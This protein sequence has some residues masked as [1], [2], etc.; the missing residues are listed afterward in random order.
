VD[1]VREV[2]S[3]EWFLDLIWGDE[4]CFVD[5]PSKAGGYW[6]P[7][8]GAWPEDRELILNRIDECS[9]GGEDVYFSCARFY[10]K[11]RRIA[12]VMPTHWLW[13]DLDVVDPVYLDEDGVQPTI[14]W[15]SSASRYQAMWRLDQQLSPKKQTKL[16]R[17]LSIAIGADKGG[18]D[19]TQVLRPID[20][21]NWKYPPY[22]EVELLWYDEDRV[23][24]VAEMRDLVR[25]INRG[26]PK[27]Q[28]AAA[29]E[30]PDIASLPAIARRLLK[31]P[32]EMVVVGERSYQLWRLERTLAKHGLDAEQIFQLVWPCAWNKHA[33]VRTGE[34]RLRTEIKK[35]LASVAS[36]TRASRRKERRGG[37]VEGLVERAESEGDDGGWDDLSPAKRPRSPF[38]DYATFLSQ[39]IET[40]R[41][42][43]ENL[44]AAGSRGIIGGEPKT[45]K[46]TFAI[47]MALSVATGRP[48]LG[49]E[50]FSVPEAGP[51]LL[52][53]EEN[54]P[55]AV[56]DLLRKFAHSYGLLPAKEIEVLPAPEGSIADEIVRIAFPSDAPLRF[57]NNYGFNLT[58][59]EHRHLLEDEVRTQGTRLVIIDPL[60]LVMGSTNLNNSHEVGPILQ[61]LMTLSVN[62]NCA[63]ALVHHWAKLNENSRMR[64]S[65]QRLLGT[66]FFHGW[67]ES[68]LYMENVTAK[69]PGY[70]GVMAVRVEREFRYSQPQDD[71]EMEWVIGEPGELDLNVGIVEYDPSGRLERIIEKMLKDCDDRGLNLKHVVPLMGGAISNGQDPKKQVAL[72]A[73]QLGYKVMIKPYGRG[74]AYIIFPQDARNGRRAARE[75]VR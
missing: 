44:W 38:L 75:K 58:E 3:T 33:E 55:W 46:S 50:E 32:P 72:M 53:Q 54:A 28:V 67:L 21:Y 30:A 4:K 40:P 73:K 22:D 15:E 71:L 20:T 2:Q 42:L 57:L 47:P 48:F 16:N 52:I 34:S 39:N 69:G 74:P 51:V 31:T 26:E 60:Y 29:A 41:W 9:D 23:Y 19:L 36:E 11:G 35:A 65:G 12:D 14:A 66:A 1:E 5:V 56:Q 61:W 17:A 59:E 45:S 13:A 10:T 24:G 7:W 63:I 43:I 68:G 64:R 18:W 62:Y 70:E 8:I 27:S 37:D 25:A 6:V 49:I